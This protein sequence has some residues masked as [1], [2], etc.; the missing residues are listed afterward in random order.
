MPKLHPTEEANLREI[1]DQRVLAV[2]LSPDNARSLLAEIDRLRAVLKTYADTYCEGW[3]K[4]A[5]KGA[6]FDD[7]GACL[8]R[9]ALERT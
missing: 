3:C 2:V 9:L 8:A 1:L 4:E 6:N 5:T 7:C